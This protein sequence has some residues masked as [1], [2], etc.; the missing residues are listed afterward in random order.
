MTMADSLREKA[1]ARYTQ[2]RDKAGDAY[3]TGREKAEAALAKSKAKASEAAKAT[4]VGARTAASKT[5]DSVERNPLAALVGG[6][7]IGAIAAA[8]LPRTAREDK[9]VGNVGSKVRKTAK[10][11]ATNARTAAKDQLSELGVSTGAAKDQLRDLVSK[12][13]QAASSAGSAAAKTV[14]KN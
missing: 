6:L 12:V 3:A 7:A 8:L 11:A 5:V 13:G 1:S 9:L 10:A 14:R 4:R 2:A